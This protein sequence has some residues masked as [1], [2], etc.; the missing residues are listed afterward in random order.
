MAEYSTHMP[1]TS[2]ATSGSPSIRS[3]EKRGSALGEKQQI[4]GPSAKKTLNVTTTSLAVRSSTEQHVLPERGT[5]VAQ[6]LP[7][8]KGFRQGGSKWPQTVLASALPGSG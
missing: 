2:Q 4:P 1:T 6:H 5:Q 7:R 3:A 8:L